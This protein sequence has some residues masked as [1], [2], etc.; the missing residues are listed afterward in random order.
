MHINSNL[1][2]MNLTK[3][4]LLE[5]FLAQL[6]LY[7]AIFLW[8]DHVGFLLCLIFAV[9]SFAIVVI[10]YIV[11][12]IEK[13]RVPSWY[14]QLLWICVICPVL[15]LLFFSRIGEIRFLAAP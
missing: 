11:E 13:S 8:D 4:H 14:Y 12:F 10:S 5:I 9:I 15:V 1:T 6:V 3:R 2:V 7:I